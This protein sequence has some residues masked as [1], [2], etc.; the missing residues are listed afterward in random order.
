MI[1]NSFAQ[2]IEWSNDPRDEYARAVYISEMLAERANAVLFGGTS[3]N[4]RV[5][6][7]WKHDT[8][9]WLIGSSNVLYYDKCFIR[10]PNIPVP[11]ATASVFLQAM[12]NTLASSKR[13]GYL[14]FFEALLNGA[15]MNEIATFGN[16]NLHLAHIYASAVMAHVY[17]APRSAGITNLNDTQHVWSVLSQKRPTYTG[18]HDQTASHDT[19]H[20][21][22]FDV[23]D[24]QYDWF[25][26][27]ALVD[28]A[29]VYIPEDF[30]F[31]GLYPLETYFE[32]IASKHPLYFINNAIKYPN[33]YLGFVYS[34]P[35]M[36]ADAP[37]F[38]PQELTVRDF[39]YGY[40][41]PGAGAFYYDNRFVYPNL[42]NYVTF[43]DG[44]LV[45]YLEYIPF[46]HHSFFSSFF[47]P[48]Y[49]WMTKYMPWHVYSL[50]MVNL[51][52]LKYRP[53]SS[54]LPRRALSF[55]W[56]VYNYPQLS[57][58]QRWNGLREWLSEMRILPL[59]FNI[60]MVVNG[61]T[62]QFLNPIPVNF[63]YVMHECDRNVCG[64][65]AFIRDFCSQCMFPYSVYPGNSDPYVDWAGEVIN[66]FGYLLDPYERQWF[67]DKA[68]FACD[69]SIYRSRDFRHIYVRGGP[70]IN[71]LDFLNLSPIC[72][73]G[74][75][76]VNINIY[77][78]IPLYT[79]NNLNYIEYFKYPAGDTN[80][81][82][83]VDVVFTNNYFIN[84]NGQ[85]APELSFWFSGAT[86]EY[87]C[88]S[89]WQV[90]FDVMSWSNCW[91]VMDFKYK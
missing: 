28:S 56:Q 74:L 39:D 82:L 61:G 49:S 15:F 42:S 68:L 85:Y 12:S 64:P 47:H 40:L 58:M 8:L 9:G 27:G 20:S 62:Q 19:Y 52:D 91:A 66:D 55:Y 37:S 65:V 78:D 24:R 14:G 32:G 89:S 54:D 45:P 3:I 6:S 17:M 33:P 79:E 63:Q 81:G 35:M 83:Y 75:H 76:T 44:W 2:T 22:F 87:I 77:S 71:K 73:Q 88:R 1:V 29:F 67:R 30:R 80:C 84:I 57:Y 4:G 7:G 26:Y 41:E 90:R 59:S 21:I 51:W 11:R 69:V 10:L 5:F 86:N 43:I 18:Q 46:V 16:T 34:S 48:Y 60:H 31:S 70:N 53:F 38:L 13:Y 50:K 36:R 25:P 72:T 23:Y